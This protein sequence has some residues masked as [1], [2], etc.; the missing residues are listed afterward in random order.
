MKLE[1][2][3]VSCGYDTREVISDISL[4]VECGESLCILGPNGIGKTTLFKA[5]LGIIKLQSGQILVDEEDISCWERR[6][7]ARK[8]GYVPQAHNPPFPFKVIEVVTMGRTAH[9]SFF[10]SSTRRDRE[11]AE[12]ALKTLGIVQLKDRIYTQISGGERQLVLIA[13]ALAQQPA[14]LIM[15]EPTANLDFGNQIKVLNQIKKLVRN[16]NLGVIM[17]THFP[18]DAFYCASKVAV[19]EKGNAFR[20]GTAEEV[21]T[22]DY[23]KTVYGVDVQIISIGDKN[24]GR[25]VCIPF[26]SNCG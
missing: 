14:F 19:I 11:I 21:I 18:N 22:E 23:L 4:T 1:V 12:E 2:K 24:G 20:I 26:S 5:M 8:L 6:N 3:N 9:L 10:S 7:L 13:R 15:D 25:R 17:T 16:E